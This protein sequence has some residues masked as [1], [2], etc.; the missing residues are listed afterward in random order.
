MLKIQDQDWSMAMVLYAG[1]H[2][3][4]QIRSSQEDY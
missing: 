2:A 1:S 4:Y 3:I